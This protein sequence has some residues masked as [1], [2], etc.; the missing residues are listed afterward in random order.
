[1]TRGICKLKRQRSFV[2]VELALIR[3]S[4]S[5]CGVSRARICVTIGPFKP[6]TTIL[7]PSLKIPFDKMTSM[8]VPRPSMTLTSKTVHSN[9]DKYINLSLIL[10]WVRFTNN[11]IMSGTPSPVCADVGTKETFLAKLLFS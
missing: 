1:M 10:C 8:V 6:Q 9:S 3:S 11:M 7:S 4:R 5:G 2:R